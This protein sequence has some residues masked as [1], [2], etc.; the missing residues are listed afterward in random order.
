MRRSTDA[1]SAPSAYAISIILP[2]NRC[3]CDNWIYAGVAFFRDHPIFG[4][5]NFSCHFRILRHASISELELCPANAGC[6]TNAGPV[7]ASVSLPPSC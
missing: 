3:P 7:L 6:R 4:A 2:G 5:W 1:P